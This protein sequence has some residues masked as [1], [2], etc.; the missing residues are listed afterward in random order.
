MINRIKKYFSVPLVIYLVV[1]LACIIMILPNIFVDSENKPRVIE[2]LA[3][4]G[5][6]LFASD[7]AGVLFDLGNNISHE[8]RNQKQYKAITYS[9]CNMLNDLIAIV[10]D[11]CENLNIVNYQDMTLVEQLNYILFKG[12]TESVISSKE[13]IETTED[14]SYWLDMLKKES[15]K[16]LD[17]SYIMYENENFNEKKRMHLRFLSVMTTEAIKQF[18][19]HSIQ[20]HKKVSVLICDRIIKQML[21]LYPEQKTLFDDYT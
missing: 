10:D 21:A 7:V 11:I 9:H 18:D 17:I 20:S 1:F 4:I 12:Q 16:L 8:K 15:E 14:I 3:N 6:S 19:M 13:Y 5:Y 2:I